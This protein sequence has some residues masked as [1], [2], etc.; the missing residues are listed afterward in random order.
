MLASLAAVWGAMI[1]QMTVLNRR[2]GG[3]IEPG[4]KAYDFRGWLAVSLPIL[5]VEG[6]YLL[7]SYTDVLVLQQFRPS[8]EAGGHFAGVKTPAPGLFISY[9]MAAATGHR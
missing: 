1:S 2:L 8:E 9:A 7:V 4:P 6:F 3:H 5:M